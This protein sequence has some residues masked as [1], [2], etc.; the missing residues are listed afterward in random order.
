MRHTKI[1]ATIGP[2]TEAD[3]E[4]D[5]LAK[6]SVPRNQ[7]RLDELQSGEYIRLW[8]NRGGSNYLV[9]MPTSAP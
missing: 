9:H 2:A 8:L 3:S 7:V 4:I 5:A 6:S 1:V